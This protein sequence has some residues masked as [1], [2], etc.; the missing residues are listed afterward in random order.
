MGKLLKSS[1]AWYGR[2]CAISVDVIS[3]RKGRGRAY[4]EL[5]PAAGRHAGRL[6]WRAGLFRALGR[7]DIV[8]PQDHACSFGCCQP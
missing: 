8:D 5:F 4:L 6:T 3:K 2:A 7:N 1:L